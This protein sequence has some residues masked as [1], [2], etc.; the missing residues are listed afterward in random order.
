M[1]WRTVLALGVTALAL[2]SCG[3]DELPLRPEVSGSEEMPAAF[4][5]VASP[6]RGCP[7]LEGLYAW[8]WADGRPFGYVTPT[9]PDKFGSF[10]DIPLYDDAQIWISGP[11]ESAERMTLR[12][13]MVNTDP[14][15][16]I[17]S[18]TTEWSY[19]EHTNTEF[20][21][22][23]GWVELP[24]Q[25]VT[26]DSVA[27]WYGGAGVKVSARL[28]TLADG[29]L[30]VGQRLRVWGRT[31]SIGFNNG[32]QVTFPAPD[33]VRW[34]WTRLAR[35]GPTGRDAPAMDAGPPDSR[36]NLEIPR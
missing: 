4:G 27:Y 34:H 33:R 15:M 10:L 9:Q 17:R 32:R 29:S 30:V 3:R 36:A 31:N 1:T 14:N 19:R 2:T 26:G 5:T 7:D 21:C 20:S 23:D 6:A 18:L 12:S 13:R 11:G 16:R 22:D 24:E 35:V 8:P 25:P 28:A